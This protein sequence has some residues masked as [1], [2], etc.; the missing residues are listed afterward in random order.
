M[1]KYWIIN[2]LL[3][4]GIFLNGNVPSSK[5]SKEIQTFKKYKR[6]PGTDVRAVDENGREILQQFHR[7][8]NS[9]T[10][11]KY[12]KEYY[13]EYMANRVDIQKLF[14]REKLWHMGLYFVRDSHRKFDYNNA[15]QILQDTMVKYNIIE[16]DNAEYIQPI[17]LGY[18]VD[19]DKPGVYI[20]NCNEM[21]HVDEVISYFKALLDDIKEDLS[22]DIDYIH[23][24]LNA[25]KTFKIMLKELKSN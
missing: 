25:L 15:S 3:D 8:G 11:E 19:K 4:K 7:L 2:N 1:N 17:Y 6:I 24:A 21:C 5:N 12:I 13:S 22:P 14:N 16:D 18:H 9:K 23:Y 20:V 10:V